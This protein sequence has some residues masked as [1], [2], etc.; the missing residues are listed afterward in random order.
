MSMMDHLRQADSQALG[1]KEL[2]LALPPRSLPVRRAAPREETRPTRWLPC[3]HRLWSHSTG[4][5]GQL[6]PM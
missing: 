6:C 2:A 5:S 3:R 1:S 4:G